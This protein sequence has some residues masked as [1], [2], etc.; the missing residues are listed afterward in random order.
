MGED[1]DFE[2]FLREWAT[3]RISSG[4]YSLGTHALQQLRAELRAIELVQVAK[5]RGF[6]GNLTE[7]RRRTATC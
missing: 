6:R 2:A 7:T 4:G 3:E 1:P 5:E